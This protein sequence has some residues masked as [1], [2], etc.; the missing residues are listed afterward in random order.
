MMERTING[1]TI[2]MDANTLRVEDTT[3]PTAILSPRQRVAILNGNTREAEEALQLLYINLSNFMAN[4]Q[5]VVH[6]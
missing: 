6:P 1:Q 4:L 2:H 3:I 5:P